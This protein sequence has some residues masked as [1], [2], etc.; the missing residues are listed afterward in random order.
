M[1][2]A[3][4]GGAHAEEAVVPS[5]IVTPIPDAMDFVTAAAFP[6]AYGT[7]HFALQHRGRLAAGETLLVLGAAGGVG[8][9]AVELGK[10]MGARVIAAAGSPEKLAIAREHGAD[11][12]VDYRTES[13]RDRVMELT[14]GRG[15]DVVFDP[16]GGAAFEQSMRVIGWEGRILIVGFAS[17]EIPR[18]AANMILVKNFSA[19]GVVFGEHSWRFPDDTR[20]RL[21]HLL[22]DFGAG[23]LKPRVWKTYPLEQGRDALSEMAARHVVG[24]MVLTR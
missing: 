17:G 23:Y 10:R 19:T 22:D 9:A 15:V 1:A 8:L 6:V 11:C 20:A 2:F 18:I 13:L 7:A 24:K 12:A 14:G 16:V 5:G 4:R 21:G 3:R